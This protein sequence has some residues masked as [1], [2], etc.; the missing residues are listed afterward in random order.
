MISSLVFVALLAAGITGFTLQVRR[1]RRG[2][3][4]ARPSGRHD[5]QS[6]RWST[7]A[8]VALGQGKM[9]PRPL[10]AAMHLIVYV[11]FVLINIEVL[12]IVLDGILGTPPAASRAV[13]RH[14]R[15]PNELL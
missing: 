1:L 11:G 8:R 5:R 3:A 6:E 7:M 12:E 4:L 15:R 9:G 2:L 10:A 14:I 13:G